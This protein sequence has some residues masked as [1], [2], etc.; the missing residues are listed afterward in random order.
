MT[1]IQFLA[2]FISENPGLGSVAARR[3]LCNWKGKTFKDGLYTWYFSDY[4]LGSRYNGALYSPQ[5]CVAKYGYWEKIDGGWHLT[6]K[7]R[8]KITTR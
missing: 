3:A 6:Q 8:E 5:G 1:N 4:C 2:N 7:G